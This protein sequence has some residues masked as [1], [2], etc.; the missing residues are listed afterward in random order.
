MIGESIEAIIFY[1]L[2][3][4]MGMMLY[5]YSR[6]KNHSPMFLVG[7]HAVLFIAAHGV[8][9]SSIANK[10]WI[11]STFENPGYIIESVAFVVFSIAAFIGAFMLIRGKILSLKV[12]SWARISYTV[13]SSLGFLILVIATIINYNY[14]S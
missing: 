12:P 5:R 14:Y 1:L 6:K 11:A 8:L 13:S 2:A 4:I 10:S 3:G 9:T 7:L